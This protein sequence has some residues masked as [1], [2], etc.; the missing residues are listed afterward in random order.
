RCGKIGAKLEGLTQQLVRRHEIVGSPDRNRIGSEIET[1]QP[2]VRRAAPHRR[3]ID[4]SRESR[5]CERRQCTHITRPRD[6]EKIPGCAAHAGHFGMA[7][8]AVEWPIERTEEPR[9]SVFVAS[10]RGATP[11]IRSIEQPHA[12]EAGS[13]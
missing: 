6:A 2:A 12:R 8:E 10:T 9:R 3:L 7:A 5:G 4:A 13:I 11:L 1:A